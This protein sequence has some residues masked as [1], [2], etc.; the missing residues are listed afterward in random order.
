MDQ[1]GTTE[2]VSSKANTFN[3][4]RQYRLHS[5][6]QNKESDTISNSDTLFTVITITFS[7]N[8]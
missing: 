4:L 3:Q 5:L 6:M 7:Q 8:R 2:K 1:V